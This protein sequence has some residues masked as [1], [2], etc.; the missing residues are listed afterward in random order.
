MNQFYWKLIYSL[1]RT[2]LHLCLKYTA[3]SFWSPFQT[4]KHGLS[5]ANN[6]KRTWRTSQSSSTCLC[7]PKTSA[8][9]TWNLGDL[10]LV[11]VSDTQS[12]PCFHVDSPLLQTLH[13][14]LFFQPHPNAKAQ[15]NKHGHIIPIFSDI[16]Q[17][18]PSATQTLPELPVRVNQD[19][20]VAL[21]QKSKQKTRKSRKYTKILACVFNRN[22]HSSS[23][24]HNFTFLVFYLG[25]YNT[26]RIQWPFCSGQKKTQT[27]FKINPIKNTL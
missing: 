21:K 25:Y 11:F 7:V 5:H 17:R 24:E 27:R 4:I 9:Y 19:P 15:A 10:P 16:K 23:K 12:H 13:T 3:H 26:V 6:K 14:Q 2:F 1:G 22:R 8:S 18:M 20:L